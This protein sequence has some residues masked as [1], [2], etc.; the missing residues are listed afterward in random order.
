MFKIGDKVKVHDHF[1]PYPVRGH[2]VVIGLDKM[3]EDYYSVLQTPFPRKKT[4]YPMSRKEYCNKPCILVTC[5]EGC[6]LKL[7]VDK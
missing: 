6:D 3:G 5:E 7:V 1:D 2:G 4:F